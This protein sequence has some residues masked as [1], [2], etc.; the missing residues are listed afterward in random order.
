[1][2]LQPGV[3]R[4]QGVLGRWLSEYTVSMLGDNLFFILSVNTFFVSLWILFFWNSR[5]LFGKTQGKERRAGWCG[6]EKRIKGGRVGKG[7]FLY[8]KIS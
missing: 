8:V 1:M 7:G 3:I 4:F 2:F 6:V 5:A